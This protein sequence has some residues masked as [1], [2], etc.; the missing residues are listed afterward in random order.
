MFW[1]FGCMWDLTSLSRDRTCTLCTERRSLNHPVLG[2]A[3]HQPGRC[4][5]AGACVQVLDLVHICTLSHVRLF[6][7]QWIAAYQAPLSMEFSRQE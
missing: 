5:C 2:L 7:T 3:A 4:L 1:L 6:E